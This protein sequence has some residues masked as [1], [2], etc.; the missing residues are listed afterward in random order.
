MP[1]LLRINHSLRSSALLLA[2]PLEAHLQ[3]CGFIMPVRRFSTFFGVEIA[4]FRS[5]IRHLKL[6]TSWKTKSHLGQW[7][8]S[9]NK[10]IMCAKSAPLFLSILNIMSTWAMQ[11]IQKCD[12]TSDSLFIQHEV[13]LERDTV[14]NCL[15]LRCNTV[16]FPIKLCSLVDP[17]F[18]LLVSRMEAAA[19]IDTPHSAHHLAACDGGCFWTVHWR[20]H[21]L[22]HHNQRLLCQHV[23]SINLSPPVV[24]L[25]LPCSCSFFKSNPFV[26]LC[27]MLFLHPL[28]CWF[29][30][31]R[32]TNLL[33]FLTALPT[34]LVTS[35]SQS[36]QSLWLV[37]AVVLDCV[38]HSQT[39]NCPLR[40]SQK[41][42]F[43]SP[44][45]FR[46]M[47]VKWEWINFGSHQFSLQLWINAQELCA[48]APWHCVFL[49]DAWEPILL[50]CH[51]K[52]AAQSLA[53]FALLYQQMESTR[54]ETCWFCEP[55]QGGKL[56]PI[57]CCEPGVEQ[58]TIQAR[59]KIDQIQ[60]S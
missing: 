42:L 9:L 55:D 53:L 54:F 8:M 45:S 12:V 35:S 17:C 23:A 59:E 16:F 25:H 41:P 22:Q 13:L 1:E 36:W 29:L 20:C 51:H 7:P 15:T 21:R 3:L 56:N 58:F 47:V 46:C 33:V 32:S 18:A 24:Q 37:P 39:I 52:V 26:F 48:G 11:K 57:Q 19:A 28:L 34:F 50:C 5:Q 30:S 43:I 4:S 27:Q 44:C 14:P 60:Q 49:N 6:T 40:T 38:A 10:L 31:G 2:L